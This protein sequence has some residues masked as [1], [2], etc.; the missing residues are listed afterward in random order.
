MPVLA[1]G[2]GEVSRIK[3]QCHVLVDAVVVVA[4]RCDEAVLN[5]RVCVE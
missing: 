3:R 1:Y 5:A 2:A 4:A